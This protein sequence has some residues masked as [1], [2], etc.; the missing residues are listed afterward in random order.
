MFMNRKHTFESF[1]EE[2][3]HFLGD[4]ERLDFLHA[5]LPPKSS[6]DLSKVGRTTLDWSV[7]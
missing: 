1:D 3:V 2:S 5:D 6:S 7:F 4:K